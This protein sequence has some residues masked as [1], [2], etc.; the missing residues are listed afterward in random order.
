M[1]ICRSRFF[2]VTSQRRPL[3]LAIE[4]FLEVMTSPSHLGRRVF[5]QR[6]GAYTLL[7]HR[8]LSHVR[9]RFLLLW[10]MT[11]TF[12]FDVPQSVRKVYR[13]LKCGFLHTLHINNISHHEFLCCE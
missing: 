1:K 11:N 3:A 9:R 10:L 8:V 4:D 13:E 6:R 5:V 2:Q 7:I 12:I